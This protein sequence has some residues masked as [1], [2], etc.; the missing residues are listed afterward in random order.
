MGTIRKSE[1]IAGSGQRGPL[2]GT[3]FCAAQKF[4][5][6]SFAGREIYPENP[7]HS[8][9]NIKIDLLDL[10]KTGFNT[11]Q[12]EIQKFQICL[13]QPFVDLEKG[14][15]TAEH[16]TQKLAT[17]FIP[18][19]KKSQSYTLSTQLKKVYNRSLKKLEFKKLKQLEKLPENEIA[20]LKEIKQCIKALQTPPKRLEDSIDYFMS[21]MEL[22]ERYHFTESALC[23]LKTSI[24]AIGEVSEPVYNFIKPLGNV[25]LSLFLLRQ[26]LDVVSEKNILAP[27][28][29]ES[30]GSQVR[31][32]LEGQISIRGLHILH[33]R[34]IYVSVLTIVLSTI[35][36]L[37]GTFA[38]IFAF[39]ES[40]TALFFTGITLEIVAGLLAIGIYKAL[41]PKHS[42]YELHFSI[43]RALKTLE[44]IN[45]Q[46]FDFE[47]NRV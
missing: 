40:I 2:P 24:E 5:K 13:Y 8:L 17:F 7:Y 37:S 1:Q 35:V 46:I 28:S 10:G 31:K 34:A 32:V 9:K 18:P 42:T 36:I 25:W 11:L 16:E 15:L 21:H 29:Q 23:H 4:T 12:A 30:I 19:T 26:F 47:E 22:D 27:N 44:G 39:K 45:E 41:T 38:L 6:K 3:R 14:H 33:R 20:G 43:H